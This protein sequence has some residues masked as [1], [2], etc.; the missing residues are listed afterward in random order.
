M[1]A[2][3]QLEEIQTD[4]NMVGVWDYKILTKFTY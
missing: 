2:F 4:E 1:V 3:F